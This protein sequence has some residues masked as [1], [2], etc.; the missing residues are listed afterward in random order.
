[1]NTL[2]YCFIFF[3]TNIAYTPLLSSIS[4]DR[5]MY[6]HTPLEAAQHLLSYT[7]NQSHIADSLTSASE[8]QT[9][10]AKVLGHV[11]LRASQTFGILLCYIRLHHS[12]QIF[13]TL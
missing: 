6:L 5:L 3:I 4:D 10:G 8:L 12:N 9:V 13:I 7:S 11:A 1:M 2:Q